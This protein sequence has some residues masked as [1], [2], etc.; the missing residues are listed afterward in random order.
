MDRNK[1]YQINKAVSAYFAKY[2][3]TTKVAAKDLMPFFI[4]EGIF[5]KDHRNGLP[6]REIL[7]ELDK[8]KQLHLIPSVLAEH[9]KINTNWFF[10]NSENPVQEIKKESIK[11]KES[12]TILVKEHTEFKSS[13]SP[14]VNKKTRLLILGSLPGDQ[15]LAK[16]QYYGNPTNQFWKLVSYPLG[17]MPASYSERC[18]LLL[19]NGIGLWD[20]LKKAKRKGSL[21]GAIKES[22]PN[23]FT[24]FLKEYPGIRIL[25]FN[26]LKAYNDF[27]NYNSLGDKYRIIILPSSSSAR[28]IPFEEKRWEWDE[29]IN[30]QNKQIE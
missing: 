28:T 16:N 25:C 17:S 3:S 30:L 21:D 14:L 29:L 22:E 15:S 20:V 9:K 19:K 2:P 4:K 23:D 5:N 18:E 6:I 24:I 12:K 11:K 10:I 8:K 1:I 7:L 26:G 13:F 27:I